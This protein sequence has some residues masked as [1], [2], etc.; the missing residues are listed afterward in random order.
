M[1]APIRTNMVDFLF[2]FLVYLVIQFSS[3][4]PGYRLQS[5]TKDPEGCGNIPLRS[6]NNGNFEDG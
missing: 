3:T 1:L 6:L 4:L 2:N 5:L